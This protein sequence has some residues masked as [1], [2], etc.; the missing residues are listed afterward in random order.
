MVMET[1]GKT[2]SNGFTFLTQTTV[3]VPRL[4]ASKT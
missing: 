4:V 1:I 2:S 3:A